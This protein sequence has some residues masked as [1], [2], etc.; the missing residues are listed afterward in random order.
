M[1][2]ILVPQASLILGI[3][4]ALLLMYISLKGYENLYKEKTIFLTFIVGIIIGVISI[5]IEIVSIGVGIF[6][7]VL[8]PVL[9]QLIKT[10][11]LNLRR[12]HAKK[13]TVIYGFTLGLGF[14]T[15]STPF[16]LITAG[17]I[18]NYFS[19]VF[20][21]IGSLGMILLQSATGIVIGY[22]VYTRKL[23]TYLIYSILISIPVTGFIFITTWIKTEYLQVGIVIYGAIIYWYI[24]TRVLPQIL[25]D[26]RRKKRKEKHIKIK[27]NMQ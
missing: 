1:D 22:G 18:Q 2:N 7:I 16:F 25:P 15:I 6:F 24:T 20:I 21:F 26:H 14:G 23:G 8:F 12:F 27:Q 3:I 5:I 10:I 9:E 11:V 13:E 19:L 17:T 4:P